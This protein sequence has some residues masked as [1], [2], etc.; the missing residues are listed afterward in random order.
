[1]NPFWWRV[2]ISGP[3]EESSAAVIKN[4]RCWRSTDSPGVRADRRARG[5]PHV[6]RGAPCLRRKNH[7]EKVERRRNQNDISFKSGQP[8]PNYAAIELGGV[9]MLLFNR[10]GSRPSQLCLFRS[11]NGAQKVKRIRPGKAKRYQV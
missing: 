3:S 2:R 7:S 11:E 10:R 8:F 5:E 4:S 6:V 9:R 1:M